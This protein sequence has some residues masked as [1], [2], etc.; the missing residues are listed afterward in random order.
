MTVGDHL[1]A[2][3]KNQNTLIQEAEP[4]AQFL[5]KKNQNK[6]AKYN[7]RDFQ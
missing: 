2:F 3:L 4:I 5:R 7:L 1:N 6:K